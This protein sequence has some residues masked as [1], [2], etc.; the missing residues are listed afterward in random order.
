MRQVLSVLIPLLLPT[1]LYFLYAGVAAR[2]AKAAGGNSGERAVPWTWL[3]VAGAAL[4]VV[5]FVA[6]AL[7]GGADP[8]SIYPPPRAVDGRIEPGY[9]E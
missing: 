1:L 6:F 8:G 9:F 4:V 2:R 3:A 5:T 7:F